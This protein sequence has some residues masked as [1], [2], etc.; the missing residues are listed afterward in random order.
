MLPSSLCLLL[1][2]SLVEQGPGIGWTAKKQDCSQGYVNSLKKIQLD[3]GTPLFK[4][5]NTMFCDK[6]VKILS[7]MGQS[8]W[9]G[10]VFC[11][12]KSNVLC[13]A[14][15]RS[16]QE[17]VCAAKQKAEQNAGAFVNQSALQKK[18]QHLPSYQRLNVGHPDGFA[19]W[20]TGLVDG[21]GTFFFR[22]NKNGSWDFTFKLAQSNYNLKLLGY[23]KNKLK[24]GS[25]TPAG[26]NMSQFRVRNPTVLLYYLVPLF[27]TS[28][29]ITESKA[30]DYYK[31]KKALHVY[32]Q[33][34]QHCISAFQ[35]DQLLNNI[36]NSPKPDGFVAAKWKTIIVNPNNT[37]TKGWILGFTEAKG[38]FYLV[39]KDPS[40]IV[41]G[42]GWIQ[43]NEKNLLELMRAR[44]SIKA[45]VKLHVKQKCWMLDTTAMNDVE[46]LVCFFE[47]KLKGIKAIEV[48][49]WARSFRK[50]RGDFVKLQK[51]QKSLKKAKRFESSC[52]LLTAKQ[53][54]A[55]WM[56]V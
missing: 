33:W 19:H 27:D 7:A 3:A 44:W 29:F 10:V 41:H 16:K 15:L 40:R 26:K 34:Q 30:Y 51:L 37:P 9:E 21:D 52:L 50:H 24:I 56:M 36:K 53:S 46:T 45:K 28:E 22:Q 55:D 47:G 20:L 6:P 43:A 4:Q 23:V 48:R 39:K 49:K 2:S 35:R 8:A 18:L 5:K 25:I 12:T 32:D 38:S 14:L 1:L 54:R 13:A 11:S 42:A 31:F 17:A